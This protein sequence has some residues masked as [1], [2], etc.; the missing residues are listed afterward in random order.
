M[1]EL[2]L[3]EYTGEISVDGGFC[4]GLFSPD[5]F[6]THKLL[7]AAEAQPLNYIIHTDSFSTFKGSWVLT[8]ISDARFSVSTDAI[9]KRAPLGDLLAGSLMAAEPPVEVYSWEFNTT[10]LFEESEAEIGKTMEKILTNGVLKP[11]S[12]LY[13]MEWNLEGIEAGDEHVMELISEKNLVR[14]SF[15]YSNTIGENIGLNKNDTIK[16]IAEVWKAFIQ[17][18]SEIET[19]LR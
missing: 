15:A 10:Y 7:P 1:A 18:N 11:V 19:L 9:D 14:L 5:W 13:K 16:H 3:I 12:G 17:K 2:K 4:P 8:R 6:V